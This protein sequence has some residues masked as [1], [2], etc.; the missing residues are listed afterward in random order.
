MKKLSKWILAF[1]LIFSAISSFPLVSH[2]CSCVNNPDPKTAMNNAE[3]VFVGKVL[4]VKQERK[5]KGIIGAIEYRDV[6]L[7]QVEKTWKGIEQS[8][9]MIYDNGHD[10]S[11]GYVFEE[12]KTYI[13]Y[14]YKSKD[15]ELYTSYCSRT[16]ELSHANADLEQLGKGKL[17]DKKVN[18][19]GKM[20]WISNKDYDMEIL[21][22][23]IIVLLMIVFIFVKKVRSEK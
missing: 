1:V 9:I 21:I 7:F 8:Q 19:E 15:G 2:A 6:N 14:A 20:K 10:E 4:K 13:I 18:L 12:G 16:A 17:A 23:G 11:C 3:A 22:G 5:Q